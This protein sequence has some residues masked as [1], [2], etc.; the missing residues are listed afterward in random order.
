METILHGFLRNFPHFVS[1]RRLCAA[2]ELNVPETHS[3]DF[4]HFDGD[5]TANSELECTALEMRGNIGWPVIVQRVNCEQQFTCETEEKVEQILNST[6]ALVVCSRYVALVPICTR[7]QSEWLSL[8]LH[9]SFVGQQSIFRVTTK[10]ISVRSKPVVVVC[11]AEVLCNARG[12]CTER[13]RASL[14]EKSEVVRGR[15]TFNGAFTISP[16]EYVH[17]SIILQEN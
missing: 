2:N 7:H 5:A 17:E 3:N 10:C 1:A 14:R 6:S 11:V 16:L 15:Y 12:T 13:K 8:L 9:W 4:N